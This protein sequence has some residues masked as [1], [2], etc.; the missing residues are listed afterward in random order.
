MGPVWCSNGDIRIIYHLLFDHRHSFG[1][2]LE[3]IHCSWKNVYMCMV[4]CARVCVGEGTG[5]G[6]YISMG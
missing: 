1:S 6:M 2:K 4:V 3:G 5:P